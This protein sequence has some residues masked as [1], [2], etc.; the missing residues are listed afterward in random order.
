[1]TKQNINVA[2]PQEVDSKKFKAPTG[3][4]YVYGGLEPDVGFLLKGSVQC[5][6]GTMRFEDDGSICSLRCG[7]LVI[8]N[9]NLPSGTG[10]F[11]LRE[12]AIR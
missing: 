7:S 2:C 4:Q 8:V 12:S 9:D 1:V 6:Q 10:N 5:D 3:Y 11:T